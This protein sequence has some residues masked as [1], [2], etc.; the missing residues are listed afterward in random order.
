MKKAVAAVA[1]HSTS[2]PKER[3]GVAVCWSCK[4]PVATDALF[5]ST[6]EAVQPPGQTDH[7]TRLGLAVAF[8]LDIKELERRYFAMQ[9]RLHPDRFAAGSSPRERAL[10]QQQAVSL[11]DAYDVLKDPL[12]RA[13][14]MIHLKGTEVLPEGCNLVNDIDLLTESMELREA[15]AAAETLDDVNRLAKRAD[16]DIGQCIRELS[17][18][19]TGN[20]LECACKL[21]TRLKYLKRLAEEARLCRVRMAAAT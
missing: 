15:L 14:Y 11:N 4:G 6:C 13:D 19:F 1:N 9:R 20:D 12:S 2:E 5:C 17:A 10:S 21:T 8:D 16:D 3:G 18:Y 7:F